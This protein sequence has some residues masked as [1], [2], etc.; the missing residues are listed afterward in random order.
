MELFHG[1]TIA[2]KD[3]ALSIL[4]RFL[5]VAMKK[6]DVGKK[7][8]VLTATSGDT[9]K[10]A[11][12]GFRDVEGVSVVVF[13]PE[14]GVSLVQKRQMTTQEGRNTHVI[15]VRGNFDD[16]QTGV[17][18][19]FTDA[20]L[21]K[22]LS[23][24]GF[25]FSSANSINIGRLLPQI[26]YYFYAYAQM[27][28]GGY[29]KTGEPLNFTVPTGN[30]GNILAGYYAKNMGLPINKLVCASNGNKVLFDFFKT[31]VYDKNREFKLTSSPSMDILISSNLER[32]LYHVSND[33]DKVRAFMSDLS[34]SG[35]YG[36]DYATPDFEAAYATEDEAADAIKEV[37]AN[38]Y[39]M[40]THT[41]VGYAAYKKYAAAT[42]DGTK[43][44]FLATAS[45]FK[46]AR[47]VCTAIDAKYGNEDELQL[48]EKLSELSGVPV[49][50]QIAGL[51]NKPI[52]HTTV[53]DTDKMEAEVRSRFAE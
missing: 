17:K 39:V 1:R 15:G 5:T 23:D 8:T 43:N 49:P 2:F 44:I 48:I 31:K 14:D 47:A 46:F 40:D 18:K 21:N 52:L 50:K 7:I 51:M 30:F 45:P 33:G 41:A 29:I 32:L 25:M 26:V 4:P 16:T 13:F 10:A 12:E 22:E 38:G 28:S 36:F 34:G 3:V 35:R 19:M 37:Y 53:C 24:R 42:G 6:Y 20:T 27:V 9:G 11:L